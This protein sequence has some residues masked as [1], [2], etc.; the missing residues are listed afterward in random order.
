MLLLLLSCGNALTV[1]KSGLDIGEACVAQEECADG[2]VCDQAGLCALP[3]EPGTRLVGEECSDSLE[4]AYTLVCAG[5]HLCAEAGSPGTGGDGEACTADAD[6]QSGFAC[7]AG[8]CVDLEIPY[9]EGGPCPADDSSFYAVFEAPRLP[10][11]GQSDFFALPYPNNYRLDVYGR[12]DLSGF[13]SPGEAAPAVD[14]LLAAVSEKIDGFGVN[15]SIFFRFSQPV[16]PDSVFGLAGDATVHFVSL[17]PDAD[18]YG[19]LNA[20]SWSTRSTR[21]RYMCGNQVVVS[22]Y[23][24]E[25]LLP[26]HTYGVWLTNGI[27]NQ[28][29]E[30]PGRTEELEAVLAPS[31]PDGLA[32]GQ[33]WDDYQ[34][35][36]DYLTT[37]GLGTDNI[38][39]A[40][41]FSTGASHTRT[42]ALPDALG[43]PTLS[44]LTSC[45]SGPSPC[46]DGGV[47]TCETHDGMIELHAKI[48]LPQYTDASGAVLW[49]DGVNRPLA[50]DPEAV[51]MVMTVPR[52]APPEDGWPVVVFGGDVGGTF[53]DVVTTGLAA[54]MAAEGVATLG[55]EL[56]WHGARSRAGDS[57]AEFYAINDPNAWLGSYVQ[58]IAD[59]HGLESVATDWALDAPESPT[60]EALNL[61][62]GQIWFV[63]HGQGGAAGGSYLAWSRDSKGGALANPAGWFAAQVTAQTTPFDLAHGLQAAFADADLSVRHPLVALLQTLMDSIDPVSFAD[64]VLS[65]P[66][67]EARHVH[68][69]YGVDD[70]ELPPRSIQALDLAFGI[71]TGGDLLLDYGQETAALPLSENIDTDDGAFTGGTRQLA[72]GHDVLTGVALDSV[73][74]FVTSGIAG[75]PT[76]SE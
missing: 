10:V 61:D 18:D 8:A 55:I 39:S 69:V 31:R 46:D 53:R 16:N 52:G 56:P 40:T 54:R 71:P 26:G 49:E 70:T 33:I 44:Q 37:F 6:C 68:L 23:D 3:G 59:L 1:G 32:N 38:V 65:E 5:D 63:G 21:S 19:A 62:D 7:D 12:P 25:P 58:Q 30:T 35:L 34:P 13:P 24:G 9:W 4:C 29:G 73:V 50:G 75:T 66:F 76:I 67:V 27:R 41:V 17:D 45:E 2:L 43:A 22:V 47:R 14:L 64:G 15:P 11:S 28:A 20:L 51:C 42:R 48:S 60:G 57:A 72:S 74:G 36:R